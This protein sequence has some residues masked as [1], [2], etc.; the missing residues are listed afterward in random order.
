MP[1]RLSK[2]EIVTIAL[3]AVPQLAFPIRLRCPVGDVEERREFLGDLGHRG[4]ALLESGDRPCELE[5]VH[6]GA[7]GGRRMNPC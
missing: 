4:P 7:P 1:V 5:I 3:V 6:D 2:E